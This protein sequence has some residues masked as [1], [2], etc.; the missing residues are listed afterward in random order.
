VFVGEDSPG[1]FPG[2]AA[3]NS[4]ASRVRESVSGKCAIKSR[5]ALL[6]GLLVGVGVVMVL[7][8]FN[9]IDYC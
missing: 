2:K 1:N 9:V 7:A 5:G 6:N 8:D 4:F 3:K